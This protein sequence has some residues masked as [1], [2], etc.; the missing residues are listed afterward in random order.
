MEKLPELNLPVF[1]E[2]IGDTWIY[3]PP[4]ELLMTS[5]YSLVLS[6][7]SDKVEVCHPKLLHMAGPVQLQC[8]A[9]H[10]WTFGLLSSAAAVPSDCQTPVTLIGQIPCSR[11]LESVRKHGLV[12][13]G[14]A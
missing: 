12:S 7:A 11:M 9:L 13:A 14:M 3:G 1:T 8:K 4:C 2:E 6:V 5:A 10:C